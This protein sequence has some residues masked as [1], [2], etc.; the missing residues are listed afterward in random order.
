MIILKEGYNY[1]WIE[2]LY[3]LTEII[4]N[5][6]LQGYFSPDKFVNLASQVL[7]LLHS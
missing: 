5:L 3:F 7:G 1:L 2:V 4:E 6:E